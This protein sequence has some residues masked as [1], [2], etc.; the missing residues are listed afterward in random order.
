MSRPP[1]PLYINSVNQLY[2]ILKKNVIVQNATKHFSSC[3]IRINMYFAKQWIW[4]WFVLGDAALEFEVEVISLTQQTPW[5][6]VV[7]D[8]FPLVCLALVPTLL[9]LVGLYLYKK[10]SAQKP[11]KKKAKDKKIKKK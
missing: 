10:A 7:N 3:C 5:Q 2:E 11:S 8:V 1:Q 9:G 6:K 4:P